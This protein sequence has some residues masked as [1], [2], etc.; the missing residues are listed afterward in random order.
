MVLGAWG[1]GFGVW[2]LGLRAQ[3]G[4]GFRVRG[5]CA[6]FFGGTAGGDP[7]IDLHKRRSHTPVAT[8]LFIPLLPVQVRDPQVDPKSLLCTE[9]ASS[10]FLLFACLRF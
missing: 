4:Y 9:K 1:L 3:E 10:R 5:F 7:Y 6:S 8:T 2:G